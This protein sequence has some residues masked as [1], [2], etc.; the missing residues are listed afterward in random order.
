MI[1][2]CIACATLQGGHPDWAAEGY[3][4]RWGS[5]PFAVERRVWI[6]GTVFQAIGLA[7][8]VT[9]LS[10]SVWYGLS[11]AYASDAR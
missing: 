8:F 6:I 1:V 4:F 10:G 9:L 7:G 11:G 3:M 5:K 2:A